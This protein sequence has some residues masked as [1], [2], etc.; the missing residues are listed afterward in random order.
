LKYW[1]APIQNFWIDNGSVCFTVKELG[2]LSLEI[3]MTCPLLVARE[4]FFKASQRRFGL[5]HSHALISKF[6][7]D[8]D[9]RN[10]I[11]FEDNSQQQKR[12]SNPLPESLGIDCDSR[13]CVS[14]TQEIRAICEKSRKEAREVK[15]DLS[16]SQDSVVVSKKSG[17][18]WR[19]IKG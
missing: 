8:D 6:G 9:F 3:E 14:H 18:F 17:W 4:V 1:E 11:L 19:L 13:F 7:L 5:N 10:H 12:Y 16:K 15:L 2:K